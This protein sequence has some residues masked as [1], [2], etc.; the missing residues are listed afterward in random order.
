MAM[1]NRRPR[2]ERRRREKMIFVERRKGKAWMYG[3]FALL[4]ILLY[5]L[6]KFIR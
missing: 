6:F 2:V 1:G 4:V 5:L 3:Q